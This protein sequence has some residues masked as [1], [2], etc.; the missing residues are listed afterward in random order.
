MKISTKGRYALRMICD[1]AQHTGE[2]AVPLRD[3]TA[4]QEISQKYAEA[5]TLILVKGG[6]ICSERG[7]EG[8][9]RLKKD[10]DDITVYDIMKLTE[11]TVSPMA[12]V[13]SPDNICKR[14]DKCLT[15]PMWR[16]LDEIIDSYLSSVTVADLTE[17]KI[18]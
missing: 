15:L 10:A 11:G 3:I 12:C 4:R 18:R 5:I 16:R 9:Y 2:G 17:G 8:G 7:K 13:S 14:A 6:L 1:L